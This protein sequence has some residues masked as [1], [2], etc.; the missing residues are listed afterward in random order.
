[1]PGIWTRDPD[2]T[3][4][5]E[6]LRIPP[7]DGINYRPGPP[8]MHKIGVKVDLTWSMASDTHAENTDTMQPW[9]VLRREGFRPVTINILPYALDIAIDDGEDA[10][11]GQLQWGGLEMQW[12]GEDL[13]WGA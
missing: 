7:P 1:M 11:E 6:Y 8:A 2:P 4:P 5:S 10:P 3:H 9:G 13:T 12:G